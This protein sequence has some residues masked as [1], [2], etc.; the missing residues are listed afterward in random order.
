MVSFFGR[1]NEKKDSG[2]EATSKELVSHSVAHTRRT[3]SH[4]GRPVSKRSLAAKVGERQCS[5]AKDKEHTSSARA[6]GKD[7][8]CSPALLNCLCCGVLLRFPASI[9]KFRCSAC[10]VTVAIEGS[11]V[12]SGLD[13]SVHVSCSLDG[14]QRVVRRCH[15]DLQQLKKSEIS[16]KDRKPLIFQPVT[17]YLQD[18]FHDVGILNKSFLIYD[19]KR[20]EKLLNYE[21]L[22]K[23]YGLLLTLPTRKPYYS[24]LCCCN[25]LLKRVTVYEDEN[26]QISQYR[27]LLIILNIPTI[28]SCLIR[29]RKCRNA[30]ETPQ[31]RALSYELVKRCIGYLSNISTRTSQQLIQ[32]LRRLSTYDFLHQVEILNLYINFQFSRL[33]SNETANC[34]VSNNKKPEDEMRSRL[35]RHHTTGHE[36]LSTRPVS[37]LLDE[38]RDSDFTHPTNAKIK[39]KVYQYEDNWH[40]TSATR[41]MLIYYIANTR[42]NGHKALSIQS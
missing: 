7:D 33:L 24:M 29:D 3:V 27:W 16:D 12:D 1:P 8:T 10:Q 6:A 19:T 21:A 26:L 42:R 40:I 9:R 4:P 32:T 23:F 25:N 38:K 28:R 41:L 14:L 13:S 5:S 34:N 15:D 11:A 20:N 31:I 22:Q 18:R 37:A 30:F 17:T 35:R 2:G 39:F 36:F